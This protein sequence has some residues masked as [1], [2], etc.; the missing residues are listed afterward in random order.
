[1]FS[2]VVLYLFIFSDSCADTKGGKIAK[3]KES[4]VINFDANTEGKKACARGYRTPYAETVTIETTFTIT[5]KMAEDL[6]NSVKLDSM[7]VHSHGHIEIFG[8]GQTDSV[9]INSLKA[10]QKYCEN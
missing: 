10:L 1:M 7:R 5:Y 6:Y 8:G 2:T 3:S 4:P 9:I